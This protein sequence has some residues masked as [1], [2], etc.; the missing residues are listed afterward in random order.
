MNKIDKYINNQEETRKYK[1]SLVVEYIRNNYNAEE[2]LDYGLKTKIP[3]FKVN[4]V[5]V[6][7]A[8]MKNYITIHFGKYDAT[9]IIIK[10]NPKIV[11]RVGCVNISDNVQFP[12]DDIKQAIDYCFKQ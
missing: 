2:S 5:Y 9:N 10:N 12:I 6:A 1:I 7:V 8:N 11:S 4:G 3:M